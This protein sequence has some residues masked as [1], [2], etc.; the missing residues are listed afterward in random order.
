MHELLPM[1][2]RSGNDNSNLQYLIFWESLETQHY[3]AAKLHAAV[4]TELDEAPNWNN[5]GGSS[6]YESYNGDP[7]DTIMN[8]DL[9]SPI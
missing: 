5:S 3:E 2:F 1:V 6:E 4:Q 9:T 8:D 7:Q